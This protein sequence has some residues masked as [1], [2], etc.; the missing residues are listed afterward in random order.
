MST[1]TNVTRIQDL[2]GQYTL[3]PSHSRIGFVARHAMI[4]KVRGSFNDVSGVA[5]I[6]PADLVDSGIYTVCAAF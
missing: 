1:A 6:N 3:D 5:T 2:S 4:A